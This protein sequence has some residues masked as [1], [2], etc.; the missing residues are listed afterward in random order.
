MRSSSPQ[1]VNDDEQQQQDSSASG[2]DRDESPNKLK[3]SGSRRSPAWGSKAPKSPRGRDESPTKK[4]TLDEVYSSDKLKSPRNSKPGGAVPRTPKS[5]EKER[6]A[7][8]RAIS[9]GTSGRSRS[10]KLL[11]VSSG[12]SPAP[13]QVDLVQAALDALADNNEDEELEK[14]IVSNNAKK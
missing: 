2:S 9:S 12:N 10:S 8:D 11:R 1:L 6:K 13:V 3:I 5:S 4:V 7:V 14:W